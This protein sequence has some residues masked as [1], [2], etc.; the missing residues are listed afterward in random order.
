MAACSSR[1]L[2][3]VLY[4]TM[5]CPYAHRA[6]LTLELRPVPHL[7]HDATSITTTNQFSVADKVGLGGGNDLGMLGMHAGKTV[8]EMHARKDA[9]VRDVN[10]SGEVPS[11][12][13][14]SG[15][16]VRESEVVCEY[17]DAVSDTGKGGH[18]RLMPEDPL[19]A[20]RVR[21]A[22]KLFNPV[23]GAMVALLKNQDEARDEE[24]AAALRRMVDRFVATLDEEARF[25]FEGDACTL[26]DVH[27]APFVYRF[28]IVL[29][30]YRGVCL[31]TQH[32]RLERLLRAM[33][34]LP[35][36]SRVLSPAD[37]AYPPISESSLIG[38][39]AAYANNNVWVEGADGPR[40][41]GRGVSQLRPTSCTTDATTPLADAKRQRS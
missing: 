1:R 32:P 19:A 25:C 2:P 17:I 21:I 22:M 18:P 15:A 33:E 37:Q 7:Q 34:S 3:A 41:A 9:F 23:P 4:S 29:R 6:M 5:A 10:A 14:P 16:V 39:Y 27:V 24:L 20:A 28:G 36:W 35:Q 38:L 31:L 11:L 40:L 13:L 8:A 30:H 12:L 26:A